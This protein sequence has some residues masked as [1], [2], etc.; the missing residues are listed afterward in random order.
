MWDALTLACLDMENLTQFFELGN[1]ARDLKLG[2]L[3]V[4]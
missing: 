1:G 2:E 3:D 4:T